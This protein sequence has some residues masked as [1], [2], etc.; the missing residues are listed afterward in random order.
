MEVIYTSVYLKKIEKILS[1]DERIEA[2]NEIVMSPEKGK[3]ISGTGGVRKIRARRGNKGKS[4]GIRII[5]YFYVKK[6]SIYM[7]SAYAKND[8]VDLL[9]SEKKSMKKL[10]SLIEEN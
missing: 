2:E 7:L 4:G 5:Y 9:P 1:L 6:N 8:K 10:I 3:V